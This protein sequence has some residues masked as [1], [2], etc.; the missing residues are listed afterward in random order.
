MKMKTS[1][2]MTKKWILLLIGGWL[3]T[4]AIA[5]VPTSLQ[6]DFQQILDNSLINPGVKGISACVIMPD[7][8]VWTGHAGS[9]GSGVNITDTTVFYGG[10]TTKTFVAT[11]ILQLWEDGLI[12]LDTAYV[13]YIDTI[14]FV[15]PETTIRQM[16]NHTSG[17]FDIDEH[18]SF[19]L[20]IL[21]NPSHF[22]T[23]SELFQTYLNQPHNFAPGT[24]YEYSNSN[25]NIL[26]TIIE[27][28]TGHSLSVELRNNIFDTIPLVH[29]YFG[30]YEPF[31]EPYCGLW[32]FIDT[33]L[34]DL[35]AFPHTS[36][37]TSAY[38]AGNI[39]SYPLD[40]ALLIRKL[41]NGNILSPVAL[42]E[43][44]TMNSF[45][46]DY[47][48]GLIGIPLGTDTMLYVH[49][50]GI[51]NLTD[52]FH[53]PELNLTVVVMQNSENGDAQAFN[54]LFLTAFN[55]VL[56]SDIEENI[57]SISSCIYPNPASGLITVEI[58]KQTA[59]EIS[60]IQGQLLKSILVEG[61]KN[62]IEISD[63]E[64]GMYIIRV[65][66]INGIMKEIY[67]RIIAQCITFS[68][69]AEIPFT[70]NPIRQRSQ[71]DFGFKLNVVD[72]Y[73]I[74]TWQFLF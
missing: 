43:M 1:N 10:S 12:N 66:T 64:S 58:S 28:I 59:I 27:A 23:P 51:G 35:T 36:L 44:K 56:T 73:Q 24:N 67:K 60:N 3:C 31:S 13:A 6:N 20:D 68:R 18:P 57:K 46:D 52:M 72:L 5:Q 32:M 34:T 14:D 45:S 63:F 16:L 65:F 50:G 26:G 54:Y 41:I 15:L 11:R 61:D 4:S 48:L 70:K 62:S 21:N 30:A 8:S 33:T 71:W 9:N 42:N 49:N 29:T 53:S 38:S 7:N 2:F 17:I 74:R 25:Y 22:Y 37:L 47:G 69:I 39:V 55:Y 40:E 19:F